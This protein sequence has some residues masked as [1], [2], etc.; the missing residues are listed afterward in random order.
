MSFRHAVL[1]FDGTCTRVEDAADAYVAEYVRIFEAEVEAGVARH[2][3]T[4]L[5]AARKASPRAGWTFATTEAA[6]AGADPYILAFEAMRIVVKKLGIKKP[7]PTSIHARA[8]DVA[9]APWREEMVDVLEA[10]REKK[11]TIHFVSNSNTTKIARRLD[12]LLVGKP[13][14][15]KAITVIGDAGK[16]RV[17]E[18]EADTSASPAL[19]KAFAQLPPASATSVD[20]RPIYLRRGSYFEALCGVW[21]QKN[22][23][24]QT[25]VC[26][27]IWELDLAM[28]AALG[29]HVHLVKREA[30]YATYAYEKAAV[31]ELGARASF[32]S[33][34][35]VLAR[36]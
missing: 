13:A 6:P 30:P 7:I 22:L 35:D 5:A 26:G 28:P 32:G 17:H 29:A 12:D 24:T 15:R 23:A 31:K 11:I 33:L 20:G 3:H 25:L 2:F 34:R 9:Q 21:G 19:C 27:D 18:L 14:L 36:L 4:A 8:N 10:F 16:F 1:D